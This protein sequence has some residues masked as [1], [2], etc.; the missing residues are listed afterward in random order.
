MFN[1]NLETPKNDR[2]NSLIEFLNQ[3]YNLSVEKSMLDISDLSQNSWF[4]GF[5]EADGSFGIKVADFKPK[6]YNLKR[7]RSRKVQIRFNISL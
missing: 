5:T 7:S 2:L 3:K 4:T 1:I 6:A